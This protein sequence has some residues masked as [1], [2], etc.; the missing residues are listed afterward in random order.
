[1]KIAILVFLFLWA[2]LPPDDDFRTWTDSSGKFSIKAKLVENKNG[3]VVLENES[4]KQVKVP[5]NRMSDA[6]RKFLRELTKQRYSRKEIDSKTSEDSQES[7]TVST[8]WS[9]WRGPDRTGVSP[10]KGL[11][12]RWPSD[13]PLGTYASALEKSQAR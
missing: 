7:S 13:G 9:S 4:G 6:D 2:P 3:T 8:E 5:L 11:M 12:N 10:E 1:M